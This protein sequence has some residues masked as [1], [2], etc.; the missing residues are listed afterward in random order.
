MSVQA[1]QD[2]I[3]DLFTRLCG[4][5]DDAEVAAAADRALESLDEALRAEGA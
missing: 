4:D 3:V 2:Q 1:A 5:P